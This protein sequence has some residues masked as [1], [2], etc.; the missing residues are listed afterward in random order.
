M[1]INDIQ[2]FYSTFPN[3]KQIYV[4]MSEVNTVQ[5]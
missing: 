5:I 2:E 4:K 3:S 1:H